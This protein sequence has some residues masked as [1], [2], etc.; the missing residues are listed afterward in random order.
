MLPQWV[1]A[2]LFPLVLFYYEAI[3]R[4]STVRGLWKP[5]TIWMA[6]LC[7]IWG[8]TFYPNNPELEIPEEYADAIQV[9]VRNKPRF[10]EGVLATDYYGYLFQD[11]CAL[12][13]S[14]SPCR[15]QLQQKNRKDG[16]RLCNLP[17]SFWALWE[18]P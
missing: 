6:L 10:C 4:L 14:H 5:A 7:I 12:P 13:H 3:F 1:I 16:T 11:E 8:G 15:T 2:A 18:W 17:H 9:T